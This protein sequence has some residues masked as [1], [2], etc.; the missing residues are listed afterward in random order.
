MRMIIGLFLMPFYAL[1]Q[2]AF[3]WKESEHNFGKIEM[4]VPVTHTFKF[5]N[6]GKDD[7]V[8]SRIITSCGCTTAK[9]PKQPIPPG[10]RGSV[11]ATYS[12]IYFGNFQKLLVLASNVPATLVSIKLKGE[13]VRKALLK[14]T[15]AGHHNS[16][17]KIIKFAH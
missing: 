16:P 10:G 12:A 13:V 7:L 2:P 9:W 15:N 17:I 14:K 4:G 5:T 8:I 6:K 11:T 1:A 3:E